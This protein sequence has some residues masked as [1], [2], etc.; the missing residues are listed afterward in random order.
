MSIDVEG[1]RTAG[2]PGSTLEATQ[3][4]VVVMEERASEQQ[5]ENVV[6]RLVELGMDVHRST[7]ATRTVLGVVGQTRPDPELISVLD[8]VHEVLRISEPLGISLF[9][10]C[11]EIRNFA[12]C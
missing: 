9:E 5:I 3:H 7:G 4:M 6:A 8:G 1:R 12:I 10:Q 2:A 11:F